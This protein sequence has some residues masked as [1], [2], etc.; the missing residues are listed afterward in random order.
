MSK[1]R[2]KIKR[3]INTASAKS[4]LSNK[5]N[6]L[7]A[8]SLLLALIPTILYIS[9]KSAYFINKNTPEKNISHNPIKHIT[10]VELLNS[11]INNENY[12]VLDLVK[13]R[14]LN[15]NNENSL[16]LKEISAI[17]FLKSKFRNDMKIESSL[18]YNEID[19]EYNYTVNSSDIQ[20]ELNENFMIKNF[21]IL[22]PH[23]SVQTLD[24][25]EIQIGNSITPIKEKY[26][27]QFSN[28]KTI[29]ENNIEFDVINLDLELF[30]NVKTDISLYLLVNRKSNK[31]E[32]IGTWTPM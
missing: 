20:Y 13:L 3:S 4:T 29:K 23:I 1:K 9:S 21:K 8:L 10:Q 5:Y 27:S 2:Q 11:N 24:G 31:I 12:S 19:D 6:Y 28:S 7:K 30:T 26:P 25:I 22:N 16:E 15:S 17:R 18:H 32:E 14:N